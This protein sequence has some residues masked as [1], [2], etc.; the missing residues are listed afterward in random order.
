MSRLAKATITLVDKIPARRRPRRRQENAEQAGGTDAS[1]PASSAPD[2]STPAPTSTPA[3]GGSGDAPP[4]PPTREEDLT[5]LTLHFN[6]ET[7]DFKIENRTETKKKRTNQRVQYTG[8]SSTTLSFECIFDATR[9]GGPPME[10]RPPEGANS[11]PEALDVR[12]QTRVLAGLL[13]GLDPD[14]ASEQL[15]FPKL[16]RFEW[17]SVKFQG[18]VSSFSETLEFFS[19]EG[20]PL[21]SKVSLSLTEQ[22]HRFQVSGLSQRQAANEDGVREGNAPADGAADGAP[23][24]GME[25]IE[26][27]LDDLGATLDLAKKVAADSGLDDLFELGAGLELRLG[28]SFDVGLDVGLE[29]G[30]EADLDLQVA[31]GVDLDLDLGEMEAV[32]GDGAHRAARGMERAAERTRVVPGGSRRSSAAGARGTGGSRAGGTAATSAAP[33]TAWA[34]EGPRPGTQAAE[35]AAEVLRDRQAGPARDVGTSSAAGGFRASVP[36]LPSPPSVP[37]PVRG[38][39]PLRRSSRPVAS[40]RWTPDRPSWEGLPEIGVAHG[41]RCACRPCTEGDAS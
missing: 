3:G 8:E 22:S 21:R 38:S 26:H 11:G 14:A 20:V 33:G 12:A 40:P 27:A 32:F 13:N 23:Q 9:P 7:L 16:V 4:R 2:T 1:T 34:P 15:L 30:F 28:A 39:P 19:P 35:L 41:P 29:V 36:T 37:P 6:P 24:L 10:D 17:G 25:P 31:A 18:Y 5:S